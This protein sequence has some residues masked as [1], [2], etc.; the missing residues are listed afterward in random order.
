MIDRVAK[1]AF[2]FLCSIVGLAILW[3][4]FLVIAV[5]IKVNSPGPVFYRG[6][7]TGRYGRQ[8]RIFK[9]RTMV[10]NA[11]SIG[12]PST[13][14]G[15][16]RVT[17]LGRVLRKYKIDELPN[18]INVALGQMSLVGPRP[19]VPRYTALYSGDEEL[20][21]TV[22]PGITDLSSVRFIDLAKHIGDSNVDE[23]FEQ[24]VLPEKN[25]LRVEYV[26]TRSFM[27]DLA[28]IGRTLAGLLANDKKTD[29]VH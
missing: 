15:D 17:S 26:K 3:P 7:R 14:M 25:R 23:T 4:F 24:Y 18:L 8:F 22:R 5:A 2:D 11:E 20:I 29:G 1:R 16:P 6:V 27:G 12:G 13:G 10:F 28:I 19:E 21:L 9:F